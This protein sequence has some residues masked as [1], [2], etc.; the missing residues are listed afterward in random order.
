MK[1]DK[2]RIHPFSWQH[3]TY[4]KNLAIW[5]IFPSNFGKLVALFCDIF[6]ERL[7]FWFLVKF[8]QKFATEKTLEWDIKVLLLIRVWNGK[9]PI[10]FSVIFV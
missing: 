6:F 8:W 5:N 4:D 10:P 9:T 2:T 3:S 7:K 1:V